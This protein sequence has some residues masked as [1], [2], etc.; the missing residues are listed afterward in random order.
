[1]SPA[2]D[3][4]E[5]RVLIAIAIFVLLTL[6]AGVLGIIAWMRAPM[7]VRLEAVLEPNW[8]TLLLAGRDHGTTRIELV[9]E[10]IF[11]LSDEE[12]AA[13][14]VRRFAVRMRALD[15][16]GRPMNVLMNLHASGSLLRSTRS[17]S[18]RFLRAD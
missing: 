2:L 8:G 13:G 5:R 9:D 11:A 15:E 7:P 6:V 18:F 4:R 12:L 17:V 3:R 16:Q 1:M 14:E 10:E